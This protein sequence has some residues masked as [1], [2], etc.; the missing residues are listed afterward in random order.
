[1]LSV[2]KSYISQIDPALW[3]KVIETTQI[4]KNCYNTPN[5][6]LNLIDIICEMSELKKEIFLEKI[7]ETYISEYIK[8]H[9]FQ[10]FKKYGTNCIDMIKNINTIYKELHRNHDLPQITTKKLKLRKEKHRSIN[11]HFFGN[12]NYLPLLEGLIK[13]IGLK[14]FEQKIKIQKHIKDKSTR[15]K[16]ELEK[17]GHNNI[18]KIKMNVK[19][20]IIS[21]NPPAE[22]LLGNNIT[23]KYFFDYFEIISPKNIKLNYK[24]ISKIQDIELNYI[25]NNLKLVGHIKTDKTNIIFKFKVLESKIMSSGS[26]SLVELP[27][28][29]MS[30]VVSLKPKVSSARNEK[31]KK[32]KSFKRPISGGISI[33]KIQLRHINNNLLSLIQLLRDD[34]IG[35]KFTFIKNL[36]KINDN[37]NI[38][39]SIKNFYTETGE[40]N[41]LIESVFKDEISN[42][43]E[44]ET[45]YREDSIGTKLFKSFINNKQFENYSYFCLGAL[46]NDIF[47]ERS[48]S[49][50]PKKEPMENILRNAGELQEI[51][52]RFLENICLKPEYCPIEIRIILNII[53]KEINIKFPEMCHYVIINLFYTRFLAPFIV[54]EATNK[55]MAIIIIKTVN[56]IFNKILFGEKEMY[57]IYMNG[58][59][60]EKNFKMVDSFLEN[61]IDDSKIFNKFIPYDKNNNMINHII[62]GSVNVIKNYIINDLEKILSFDIQEERTP[63]IKFLAGLIHNINC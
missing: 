1:M 9:Q 57:M 50:D 35:K 5:T 19:M 12:S 51:T 24:T 26:R 42:S 17:E 41:S 28:L 37:Q 61:L 14:V 62:I 4:D 56:N 8:L 2:I 55:N 30:S 16:I 40:I 63:F 47:I 11:I 49:I 54:R 59:I 25:K 44:K 10:I 13:A 23:N 58:I 32:R 22:K 6:F 18:H 52:Q 3:D 7:G 53:A 39:D 48:L 38:Y 20:T 15:L 43:C 45:L 31:T 27:K 36:L 60:N 21:M 33:D 46:K 34:A 29:D